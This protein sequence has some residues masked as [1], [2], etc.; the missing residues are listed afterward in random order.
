M[1]FPFL[2]MAEE[3]G[4]IFTYEKQK[5]A[6]Y[7]YR[8]GGEIRE[9]E[10]SYNEVSSKKQKCK[11]LLETLLWTSLS[12][13][14]PLLLE[15]II[16]SFMQINIVDL[17]I[18]YSIS[19]IGYISYKARSIIK[20]KEQFS[21]QLKKYHSAEHMVLN[22]YNQELTIQELKKVSNLH[23]DCGSNETIIRIAKLLS[24][25]M[26]STI[27][28]KIL[29]NQEKIIIYLFFYIIIIGIIDLVMFIIQKKGLLNHIVQPLFLEL[30]DDEQLELAIYGMK[31][32]NELNQ[33]LNVN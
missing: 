28:I 9:K 32:I 3:D 5:K 24:I 16:M 18:L 10:I 13:G 17:W 6:I 12:G 4:I 1:T 7:V 14:I 26:V 29:T 22:V 25:G 20:D 33:N 11:D 8:K 2:A 15:M 31:R 27:F 23:N 19:M 30:P 21:V